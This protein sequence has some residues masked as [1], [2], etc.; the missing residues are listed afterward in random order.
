[1]ASKPGASQT[2]APNADGKFAISED[3]VAFAVGLIL[4]A[5]CLTGIIPEGLLP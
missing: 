4:L 3:W 1:M 5:L 2:Q